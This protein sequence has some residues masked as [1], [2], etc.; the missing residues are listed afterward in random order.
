MKYRL[1]SCCSVCFTLLSSIFSAQLN[2]ASIFFDDQTAIASYG[3]SAKAAGF[4][5]GALTYF[6]KINNKTFDILNTNIAGNYLPVSTN[7][8]LQ[9]VND[10]THP[11]IASFPQG[12]IGWS[13]DGDTAARPTY[14]F[15]VFAGGMFYYEGEASYQIQLNVDGTQL[16]PTTTNPST[17]W[18]PSLFHKV[19]FNKNSKITV[20]ITRAATEN[21]VIC[22]RQCYPTSND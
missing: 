21:R 9:S 2:A 18:A 20:I 10:D 16:P 22:K 7:I 6:T 11:T 12:S 8:S 13:F 1:V 5:A 19:P 3:F 17:N 15:T 14:T 4:T